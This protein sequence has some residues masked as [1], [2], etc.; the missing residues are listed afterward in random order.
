MQLIC[1]HQLP[2]TF[3]SISPELSPP[4]SPVA[5]A[6]RSS[7]VHIGRSLYVRRQGQRKRQRE[8]SRA[9]TYLIVM[10]AK[11]L[12][13]D[14]IL[15]SRSARR[16]R[17]CEWCRSSETND[18]FNQPS[19]LDSWSF[20]VCHQL[21]PHRSLSFQRNTTNGSFYHGSFCHPNVAACSK[22]PPF[23]ESTGDG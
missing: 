1:T 16:A 4:F 17:H 8:T 19:K 7:C 18:S 23:V 5:I 9:W 6:I 11:V 3:H 22:C 15:V 13:H 12:V 2:T 21:V 14:T 20:F 10:R